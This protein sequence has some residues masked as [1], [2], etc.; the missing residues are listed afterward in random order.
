MLEFKFLLLGLGINASLV[1]IILALTVLGLVY[2]IPIPAGLGF[3]EAGQTGLFY[4]LKG[5]GSIGFV[6]SLITRIRNLIFVAIGFSLIAYFSGG[7]VEKKLKGRK[8]HGNHV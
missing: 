3:L 5:E 7:V 8:K 6:L 2:F 4:A 1:V